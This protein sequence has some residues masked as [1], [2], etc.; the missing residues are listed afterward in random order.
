[1]PIFKEQVL[2]IVTPMKENLE[3]NYELLERNINYQID[4]G[5][6]AIIIAGTTGESATLSEEEH[7]KVVKA[8]IEFTK[9]R[10]PVIAGTGSNSTQTAIELSQE[11]DKDGADAVLIVTP[12]YNKAT[13]KGLIATLYERCKFYQSAGDHVQCSIQ[14]RLWTESG[15]HR[16]SG[17][18]M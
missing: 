15:D 5:T 17:K 14:N 6:D 8:A 16:T 18:K 10:V 12:Y 9:H 4:N 1:M 11:A 7:K 2:Q 13:Q 3:V